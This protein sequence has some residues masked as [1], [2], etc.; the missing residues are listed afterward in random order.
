MSQ[1]QNQQASGE[2]EV[3]QLSSQEETIDRT[4]NTQGNSSI[5]DKSSKTPKPKF[6]HRKSQPDYDRRPRDPI[7][8]RRLAEDGDSCLRCIEKGLICTL[9]FAGI[10]AVDKCAA[11]ERSGA[12]Y[13]FR[14]F[15]PTSRIP[16][17]GPPWKNPNYFSIGDTVGPDEME[18]ILREHFEG[19]KSYLG[20]SLLSD[21]DRGRMSLPPFNGSNLPLEERPENWRKINWTHVLPS[22]WNRSLH[23]RP[24][25]PKE[26]RSQQN[27]DE[28]KDATITSQAQEEDQEDQEGDAAGQEEDIL[29]YFG[30]LGKYEPRK[31]HLKEYFAD[32]ELE[33]T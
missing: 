23:R 10:A 14:Q 20:G 8:G 28:T 24:G 31:Q 7:T 15:V 17:E 18:A 32:L 33:E 4:Q 22:W 13:C 9:T 1:T 30:A 3:G 19:K 6:Q 12:R 5:G 11:C 25:P 2:A 21:A 16:F 26:V 27:T 29:G